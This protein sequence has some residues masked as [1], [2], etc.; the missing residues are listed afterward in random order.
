LFW[1]LG[2]RWGSFN[3]WMGNADILVVKWVAC[4]GCLDGDFVILG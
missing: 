1:Y 3:F 4:C 2:V